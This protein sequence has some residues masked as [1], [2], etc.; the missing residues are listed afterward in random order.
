MG[1]RE[2]RGCLQCVSVCKRVDVLNQVNQ[3]AVALC[4]RELPASSPSTAGAGW[5]GFSQC[6]G[7]SS[8]GQ[9]SSPGTGATGGTVGQA[10]A[11][12]HCV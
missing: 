5:G 1:S 12:S 9:T 8:P 7:E 2:P 4:D 10:R 3:P 6:W 11:L